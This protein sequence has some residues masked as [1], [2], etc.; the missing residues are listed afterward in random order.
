MCKPYSNLVPRLLK[1]LHK[2]MLLYQ[3]HMYKLVKRLSQGCQK[4]LQGCQRLLQASHK[5][6]KRLSKDCYKVVR[7]LLE[8]VQIA[9]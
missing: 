3:V 5:L 7:R 4:V 1:G 8:L 6:V 9:N 2:V